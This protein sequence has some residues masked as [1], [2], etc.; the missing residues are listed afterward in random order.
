AI[1]LSAQVVAASKLCGQSVLDTELRFAPQYM[2]Y[3]VHGPADE[4]IAELAIPVF[5]TIPASSRLTFDIGTAYAR[6]HVTSGGTLSEISGLTDTQIRGNL[7]LGSDFVVLTAGVSLPTGTS[8]VTLDQ[9]AAAGRIGND[10]LGFPVSNMGTGLAAT[11][12]IAIARPFGQW[13]LGVGAAVRRS[14]S[15]DPFDV[16]GQNFRYQPGNEI[17]ARIGADRP[18]GSGELTLG[19]TFSAFGRDNAGGSAYNT[20]DRVITQGAFTQ[21]LGT[22]ELTVAAFNMFRSPGSYASGDRAGRENIANVF[23]SLGVQAMGTL[24]EP[25]LEVRHWL[26]SVYPAGEESAGPARS[27]SSRMATIGLRTRIAAWGASVYPSAGYTV[28]GKLA[29]IDA[30]GTPVEANLTGFRGQIA[31]RLAK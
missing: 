17:R 28:L 31:V 4:T 6:A 26:Q 25:S 30:A 16:P 10:F 1:G 21:L 14:A 2:Q 29:T 11:G 22:N 27:Q 20:G 12:G 5:V 8:S 19:L 15:Y 3:Q 13:S 23:V 24:V 7:T 9:L 18:V